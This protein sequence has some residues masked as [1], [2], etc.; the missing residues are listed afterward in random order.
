[1]KIFGIAGFKNAG[2]TT[3][4]VDLIGELRSRGLQIATVKHA[5]HEFDIDHPGKDSHQHRTAGATEVI[6]S[7]ARRWAHIRE[8]ADAP[9]PTL[10]ELLQHMDKPDIVLIEGYKHGGHPKLELRRAGQNMP[11]LAA[12]DTSVCLIVSD[13]PVK[14]NLASAVP[15]LDRHDIKA[16]ADAVL[17]FAIDHQPPL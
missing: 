2:K 14:A 13:A 4:I 3:L 1:M 5:H 8:L 11:E 16:I 10:D 7:S 12:T 9:E 17:K 6:V 15:V